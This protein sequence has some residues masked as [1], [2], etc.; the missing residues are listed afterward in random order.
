M[1]KKLFEDLKTSIKEAGAIR[2][3]EVAS[4]RKFIFNELAD[5]SPGGRWRNS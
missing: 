1:D 4:S 2:R 3:G 5:K